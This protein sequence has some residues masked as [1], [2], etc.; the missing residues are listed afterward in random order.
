MMWLRSVCLCVQQS[1][2]IAV[3]K[4]NPIEVHRALCA[5]CRYSPVWPISV[6]SQIICEFEE[7]MRE[8]SKIFC[9]FNGT[10]LRKEDE[11]FPKLGFNNNSTDCENVT[12][13]L[14]EYVPLVG[15][16]IFFQIRRPGTRGNFYVCFIK[17][18]FIGRILAWRN[19]QWRILLW[20]AP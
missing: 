10:V 13:Y 11:I 15:N 5:C 8:E 20:K 16:E 4:I 17:T 3:A 12:Q 7:L 1:F 9:K 18:P 14:Q 6:T 19:I 2:S